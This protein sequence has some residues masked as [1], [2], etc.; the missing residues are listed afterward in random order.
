MAG[1]CD[2]F[3][4]LRALQ[5]GVPMPANAQVDHKSKVI[6]LFAAEEL[7]WATQNRIT[8]LFPATA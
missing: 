2:A 3:D 6:S 8:D 5:P 1:L 7:I 4:V